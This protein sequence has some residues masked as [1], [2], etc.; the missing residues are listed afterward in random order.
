MNKTIFAV[1]PDGCGNGIEWGEVMMYDEMSVASQRL[2]FL[3]LHKIKRLLRDGI[4][5]NELAAL[6][7]SNHRIEEYSIDAN[8]MFVNVNG[9][10]IED[11][12]SIL[13]QWHM[14]NTG[15]TILQVIEYAF[16]HIDTLISCVKLIH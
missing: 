10:R 3:A 6:H 5:L 12:H 8:H 2:I 15:L 4:T 7:Y 9:Y 16:V 14:Q 1:V 11:I 13:K